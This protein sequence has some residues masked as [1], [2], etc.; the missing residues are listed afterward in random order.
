MGWKLDDQTEQYPSFPEEALDRLARAIGKSAAGVAGSSTS[1]GGTIL[2][3][4]S[5]HVQALLGMTEWRCRY[6]ALVATGSVAEGC[7]E[8]RHFHSR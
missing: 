2:S 5:E 7:F 8:V 1:G 4:L 6:S 3:S